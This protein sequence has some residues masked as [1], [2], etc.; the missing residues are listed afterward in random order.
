MAGPKTRHLMHAFL[1]VLV[2]AL[3]MSARGLHDLLFKSLEVVRK[4]V[5]NK[6]KNQ[7]EFGGSGRGGGVHCLLVRRPPLLYDSSDI[8]TCVRVC[9]HFFYI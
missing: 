4:K 8:R 9:V 7:G 5:R 6:N 2:P 3:E 1:P